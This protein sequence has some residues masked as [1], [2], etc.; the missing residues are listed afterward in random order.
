[1]KNISK[2]LLLIIAL[3]ITVTGCTSTRAPGVQG[4]E[5]I[6]AK[7]TLKTM[8]EANVVLVDAQKSSA[9]KDRHVEGA[10]NIGINKITTFG[11]FPNMLA[12][13]K[14]I[15]KVLGK[16]GI[17]NNSIV[18]VY[19]DNNN[20]DAARFWW[21][22]KVYGHENVKVISGGLKAMLKARAKETTAIPD[23]SPAEYHA[24]KIIEE[25][26]ATK[27]EV[28]S[29]L[30]NPQENVVLLDVR[31]PEEYNSGTIP[32]SIHLNYLYNDFDDGTFRPIRQINV[33]YKDKGITPDKTVILYC[34]TSIRA[35]QTYLVLY[36]AGYRD[37]K[38]YDGAWIEW[39]SD[40]SLP[41]QMPDGTQVKTNFQ[42]AS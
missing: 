8:A 25:M 29:Q 10:V 42:D 27:A 41:V 19:D 4:Q 15:E 23:I 6:T 11:P 31:I 16:N 30:D 18:L 33:L 36:N 9:Y 13:A 34:K 14:N 22:M 20:M 7:E 12:P 1:M 24:G 3:L 21:T 28:K 37:L 35:A 40:T 39:S 26:I 38:L 17:S 32:G 2:L 5:I